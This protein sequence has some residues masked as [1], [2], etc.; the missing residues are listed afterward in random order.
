[1]NINC[2]MIKEFNHKMK[3]DNLNFLKEYKVHNRKFNNI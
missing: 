1:M 3:L 2:N